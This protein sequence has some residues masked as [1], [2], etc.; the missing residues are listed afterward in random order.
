MPTDRR[1]RSESDEVQ[2]SRYG[3]DFSIPLCFLSSSVAVPFWKATRSSI[4]RH[5][6]CRSDAIDRLPCA[7]L[8]LWKHI[9]INY[10]SLLRDVEHCTFFGD[11]LNAIGVTSRFDNVFLSSLLYLSLPPEDIPVPLVDNGSIVNS[12]AWQQ[13][14]FR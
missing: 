8:F 1:Y 3:K 5:Q 9:F 11:A 2:L 12:R 4:G 13:R 7:I 6:L 14:I 10:F